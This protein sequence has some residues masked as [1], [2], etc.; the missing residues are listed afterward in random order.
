MKRINQLCSFKEVFWESE[1]PVFFCFQQTEQ[2]VRWFFLG[3]FLNQHLKGPSIAFFANTGI[4]I[5]PNR[6]FPF[7]HALEI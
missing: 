3:E 7:D 5:R 1:S 6:F 2:I 4:L